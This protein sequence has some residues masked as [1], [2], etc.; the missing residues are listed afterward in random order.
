VD[1]ATATSL[2]GS[3]VEMLNGSTVSISIQGD[4]LYIND[5][6]VIAADVTATNGIIHV[7][8]AV[9]TPAES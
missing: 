8:D 2:N 5:S 1:A 6:A 9:L 3:D 7:I 4:T